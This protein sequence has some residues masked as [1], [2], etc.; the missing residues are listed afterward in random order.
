MDIYVPYLSL[1][2]EVDG[3]NHFGTARVKDAERDEALKAAGCSVLRFT[4]REIEDG[5]FV[6]RLLEV[7]GTL[8]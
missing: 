2:I 1:N 6:S 8:S 7:V 5:T 4:H 3:N